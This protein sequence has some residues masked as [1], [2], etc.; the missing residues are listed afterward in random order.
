MNWAPIS[1]HEL[2]RIIRTAEA[3]FNDDQSNLWQL[4]AIPPEKWKETKYGSPGEGF[5]A[6]AI[7]GKRVL[8]YNDIE[9]G[10]NI[11]DYRVYGQIGEYFAN[12]DKLQWA[13]NRLSKSTQNDGQITRQL[14]PPEPLI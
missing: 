3:E 4:I 10:F 6:V 2:Q 8:W 11:S 13:L 1:L 12:Q 5:W 14:G 7:S 9:E